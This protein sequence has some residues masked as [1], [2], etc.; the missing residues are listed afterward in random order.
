[1][2]SPRRGLGGEDPAKSS[3]I[4]KEVPKEETQV[5]SLND[6][7][8]CAAP[9]PPPQDP[10]SPFGE[11]AKQFARGFAKGVGEE[12]RQIYKDTKELPARL[13]KA[14]REAVEDVEAGRELRALAPLRAATHACLLYT[15][16]CV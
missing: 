9:T 3:P 5:S 2:G 7:P 10:N 6:E 1:M 12:S 8:R 16:R 15:S 4:R 13:A 11:S 14:G